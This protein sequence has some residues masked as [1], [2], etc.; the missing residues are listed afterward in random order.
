MRG[1]FSA[2]HVRSLGRH[3]RG[4][5]EARRWSVRRLSE[6][7]GLSVAAIRK[8]EAGQADPRLSSVLLLAEALGESIDRLVENIRDV[9]SAVQVTRSVNAGTPTSEAL[10]RDLTKNLIDPRMEAKLISVRPGERLR[11]DESEPA[12][13][14]F[15]YL[16]DGE[17]VVAFSDGEEQSLATADAL[18]VVEPAPVEWRN[19]TAQVARFLYLADTNRPAANGLARGWQRQ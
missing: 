10:E 14:A 18:H 15:C 8:I 13:A 3:M 12:R 9:R 6:R 7:S 4:L 1:N 16:L 5:R 11:V 2:E 19:E 17:I